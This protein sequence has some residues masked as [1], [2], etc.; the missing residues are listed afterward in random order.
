[1]R[2]EL[3]EVER[4]FVQRGVPHLIDEYTARRDIWT[5]ALPVLMVAYLAGGLLALDLDEWTLARNAV[6]LVAV[7]AVLAGTWA[8]TNLVLGRPMSARPQVVG[9]VELVVFVVG[10]ALPSLVLGRVDRAA[11]ALVGGLVVLGV[12]YLGTSYGVVPLLRWA[13]QT[14]RGQIVSLGNLVSRALPLLLLFTTFLF[15]NAEVWQV[16]GN[17][18]G[19]AYVG[20]LGV[21]FALGAVFVLSRLPG[22]LAG[23]GT[24]GSRDEVRDLVATTPAAQLPV[25]PTDTASREM[26]SIRQRVN[27]GLV[28]VF[29]QSLQ[30]TLVALVLT[31]FFCLFGLLAISEEIQRSWTGLEDVHVFVSFTLDGRPFVLTEP[32]FRVAGFL[33]AFTGMYFTVVLTTDATYAS[34]FA[35]D[36]RPELRRVFAVHLVY[37][38]SRA[39][40][41]AG[42]PAAPDG[43]SPGSSPSARRTPPR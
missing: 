29:S 40:L 23:L 4:W 35:D 14:S 30:I 34:E 43:L 33:G 3:D 24:F 5:R 2:G 36:V 22:V 21:F 39:T 8:V 18:A 1:V 42:G 17:L 32:L 15:V 10:P 9:I 6:A 19:V 37:R 28:A 31:G 12:V 16:A 26:L 38:A 11:V 27:V 13:V 7:L 41:A 20:V 25:P